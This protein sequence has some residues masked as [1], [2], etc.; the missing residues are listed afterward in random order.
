MVEE[1]S[2]DACHTTTTNHNHQPQPPPHSIATRSLLFA[3][4]SP[5]FF[6]IRIYIVNLD[7]ARPPSRRTMVPGEEPLG[8]E[9]PAEMDAA[10]HQPAPQLAEEKPAAINVAGKH[11]RQPPP[12]DTDEDG[13]PREGPLHDPELSSLST[14]SQFSTGLSVS[15][16]P[17]NANLM[18][19]T[20]LGRVCGY[21]LRCGR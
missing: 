1:R 5:S 9:K 18:P 8:E 20:S 17:P 7:P 15:L 16:A 12:P 2:G 19:R 3:D 13:R 10:E 11:Q 14:M 6:H 21:A 4:S